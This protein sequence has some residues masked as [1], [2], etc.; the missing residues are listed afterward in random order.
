MLESAVII[1]L[2]EL[3]NAKLEFRS[4]RHR[5]IDDENTKSTHRHKADLTHHNI[6]IVNVKY[7]EKVFANVRQ[8]LTRPEKDGM[9][10]L[11]DNESSSRVGFRKKTTVLH[12]EHRQRGAHD[13]AIHH[14][15]I[16]LVTET[17]DQRGS[18]DRMACYSMD[19]I[20][21]VTW[22]SNRAVKSKSTRLLRF[23]ALSGKDASTPF[24]CG[25]VERATWMFLELHASSRIIW[26][27]E[28]E[29]NLFPGHPTMEILKEIQMKM[30]K[31]GIRP[32]EFEDRIIF[33]SLFND[34]DWT[35]K[36]HFN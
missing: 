26:S 32:E 16:D 20:Y 18:H 11:S 35:T 4:F 5:E 22:Q 9:L 23:R 30:A 8:K 1:Q 36:E 27:F 31:R 33:M 14:A 17:W 6:E 7:L 21:F 12:Q 34:T 13:I 10:D 29:W 24:S 25:E 19:E 3:W 28:F 15:E 2:G